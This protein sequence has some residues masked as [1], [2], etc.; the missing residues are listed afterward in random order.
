MFL[1]LVQS[2]EKLQ[3]ITKKL[4]IP[5]EIKDQVL[6]YKDA[7]TKSST[8]AE[9]TAHKPRKSGVPKEVDL[10]KL[11]KHIGNTPNSRNIMHEKEKYLAHKAKGIV[12]TVDELRDKITIDNRNRRKP[13][14]QPAPEKP[15]AAQ[16]PESL[17]KL[18]REALTKM[19]KANRPHRDHN[20]TKKESGNDKKHPYE[21]KLAE[22]RGHAKVKPGAGEILRDGKPVEKP[23]EEED[24]V[25]VIH[26]LNGQKGSVRIE[27]HGEKFHFD[28]E[29][30]KRDLSD[31]A[32][33]MLGVSEESQLSIRSKMKVCYGDRVT[34]KGRSSLVTQ[35][36]FFVLGVQNKIETK[37]V[38]A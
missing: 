29:K 11:N 26:S 30:S 10:K 21:I 9:P 4:G 14:V 17:R 24:H 33:V 7:G 36:L 32:V 6:K 28:V 34:N 38:A 8:P 5:D 31:I 16:D 13:A 20:P 22:H 27:A 18:G 1:S 23:S 35:R 37:K 25:K 19:N 3:E 2:D 15:V 12:D